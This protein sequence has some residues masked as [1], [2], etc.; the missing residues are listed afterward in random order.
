MKVDH[1][2]A[3]KRFDYMNE[4][5]NDM[6]KVIAFIL[7]LAV[8]L[9]AALPAF[10]W[11]T[12]CLAAIVISVLRVAVCAA[13]DGESGGR[14]PERFAAAVIFASAAFCAI[15][16]E[17]LRDGV[18]SIGGTVGFVIPA[19]LTVGGLF[20]IG[21][22]IR[23]HFIPG[24]SPMIKDVFIDF[25]GVTLGVLAVTG[26]FWFVARKER[27]AKSV[28]AASPDAKSDPRSEEIVTK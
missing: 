17:L 24:R 1:I 7:C 22:E 27:E 15:P 6:K 11:Q 23:Q 26:F 8:A 12:A 16:S 20:A 13:E 5:T 9:T 18:L 19:A 2:A 28:Q 4:R 25:A 21:D 10:V 3:D 14:D